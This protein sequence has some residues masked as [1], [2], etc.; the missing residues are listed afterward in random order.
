VKLDVLD[1]V[2]HFQMGGYVAALRRAADWVA[3]RWASGH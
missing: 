2:G 1:D 3:A